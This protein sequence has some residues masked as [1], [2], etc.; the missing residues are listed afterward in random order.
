MASFYI[1]DIDQKVTYVQG[2]GTTGLPLMAF[3]ETN[4]PCPLHPGQNVDF[5]RGLCGGGHGCWQALPA[6]TFIPV[7]TAAPR[8]DWSY[9][10][11]A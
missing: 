8:P 5:S 3:L 4:L 2:V 11:N 10:L 1:L 9:D 7:P 6:L